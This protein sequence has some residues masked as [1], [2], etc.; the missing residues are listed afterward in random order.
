M[1][2]SPRTKR[3]A[4]SL[5]FTG[6][7]CRDVANVL[8]AEFGVKV[9]PAS[10]SLWARGVGDRRKR[11]GRRLPLPCAKL[12]RAYEAGESV[13]QLAQDYRVSERLVRKRLREVGAEMRPGGTAYPLLTQELLDDL[14]VRQGLTAE[15]IAAHI[16]CSESCVTWRLRTYGITRRCLR[17]SHHPE[18]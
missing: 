13:R 7:T 11:G 10:I 9:S 15:R 3:I 8:K 2:H 6:M 16:G 4:V 12:R 18:A 14:Y 5:Y 1:I 17:K